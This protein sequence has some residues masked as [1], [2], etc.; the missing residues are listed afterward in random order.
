[1]ALNGSHA[2][3]YGFDPLEMSEKLDLYAMQESEARHS[4]LAMLAAVG[5]PMSELLA[6]L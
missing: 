4:R 5:W 3:D 6:P 2:G 1:M